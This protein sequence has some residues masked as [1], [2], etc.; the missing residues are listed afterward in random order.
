MQASSKTDA[1]GAI[2]DGNPI[3]D[4]VVAVVFNRSPRVI[5]IESIDQLQ[6]I[7]DERCE[8]IAQIQ[9]TGGPSG[10][11]NGGAGATSQYG[12]FTGIEVQLTIG[13]SVS[14][15]GKN[16]LDRTSGHR[17]LLKCSA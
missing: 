11:Y 9:K 15:F 2:L 14:S 8:A 16:N 10:I 17:S 4:Q 13:P 12:N 6:V 3:E 7:Q 5:A 1:R